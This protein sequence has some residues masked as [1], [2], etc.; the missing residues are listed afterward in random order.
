MASVNKAIIVGHLGRDPDVRYTPGGEAIANISVATSYRYKDRNTGEQKEDTEWHRI[1][2]FGRLA[3]IVGQYLKKGSSAYIEG[4]LRTRK[5]TDKDGVEKYATEIVGENLQMLGD[6]GTRDDQAG[7]THPPPT[8]AP[9]PAR[10]AGA[11][12]TQ[13]GQPKRPALNF[14]DMDDDI[15]F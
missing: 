6:G 2:F 11:G 12:R 9:A 8:R 3:E 7:A 14:S 5:Y 13:N 15:P 4:R 10:Q 1:C